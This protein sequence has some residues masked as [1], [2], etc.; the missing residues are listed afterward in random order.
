MAET[1]KLTVEV[2]VEGTLEG[3]STDD[4]ADH[5]RDAT[6]RAL[7]DYEQYVQDWGTTSLEDPTFEIKVMQVYP[8]DFPPKEE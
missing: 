5:I 2:T 1:H 7:R 6:F 4:M 3:F 8:N